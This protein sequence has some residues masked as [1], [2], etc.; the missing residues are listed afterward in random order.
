MNRNYYDYILD[1][2]RDC[3]IISLPFNCVEA[4]QVKGY[5]VYSYS[6]L[7]SKNSELWELCRTYSDDAFHVKGTNIIA[8]NDEKPIARIRFSLMHELGH[9]VLGHD[10]TCQDQEDEADY[11]ASCILAPRIMIHHQI[12]LSKKGDIV[13]ANDI[14]DHFQ[15]SIAASNRALTDYHK[16]FQNIAHTTRKPSDAELAIKELFN[17]KTPNNMSTVTK[18]NNTRY[19]K[20]YEEYA[21]RAKLLHDYGYE[22]MFYSSYDE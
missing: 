2:Y 16:W 5:S 3:L 17:Q 12:A 14:H 15:I 1:T 18:R 8:Y 21:R 20:K 10:N 13:T 11:F 7:K 22:P 6:Y 19:S 4:L 9:I